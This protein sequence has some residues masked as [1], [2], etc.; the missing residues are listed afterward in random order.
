MDIQA[1]TVTLVYNCSVRDQHTLHQYIS[2]SQTL[3][4]Y[5]EG[6][7]VFF[8]LLKNSKFSGN[9]FSP[10]LYLKAWFTELS[11]CWAV[12]SKSNY[13]DLSPLW[14]S[15]TAQRPRKKLEVQ[16]DEKLATGLW[17][18]TQFLYTERN[19]FGVTTISTWW[20]V[21]TSGTTSNSVDHDIINLLQTGE[22]NYLCCARKV[23]ENALKT[24]WTHLKY[25]GF[26][27]K[28]LSQCL[29]QK[30]HGPE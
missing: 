12:L 11:F 26:S 19:K 21:S 14:L 16:N 5:K 6:Y 10:H 8:S 17:R 1:L 15:Y 18:L 22:F 28:K 23:E 27:L 4:G 9:F 7:S 30:P 24:H 2:E 3:Y 20:C 29:F 13:R 25:E